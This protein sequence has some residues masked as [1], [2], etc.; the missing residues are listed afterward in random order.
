MKLLQED[1]S[2]TAKEILLVIT[3]QLANNSTPAFQPS[4]FK[5]P[6]WAVRVNYYFFISISCSLITALAAVLALQWLGSYDRALNQSSPEDR[7]LQRQFRNDGVERWKMEQII[8][9]LPAV[10]FFALLIFSIGLAD[11]LWHLHLGVAAIAILC[12]IIGISFFWITTFISIVDVRA[13][14]RTPTSRSLPV[15][16]G[17]LYQ[18]T[19][20]L[21]ALFSWG[22]IF[23]TFR[24]SREKVTKSN[25]ALARWYRKQHCRSKGISFH[26]AVG[27]ITGL[28]TL[29]SRWYRRWSNSGIYQALKYLLQPMVCQ[30]PF[31]A[32]ELVAI[33]SEESIRRI[34]LLWLARSISI[35]PL[36][37][38]SFIILIQSFL[39]LPYFSK[40]SVD[41]YS[42]EELE[43]ISFLLHGLAFIGHEQCDGSEFND[44]YMNFWAYD[45]NLT[46]MYANL[47]WW[48]H[49]KRQDRDIY[50]KETLEYTIKYA[51]QWPLETIITAL[52]CVKADTRRFKLDVE[53]TTLTVSQGLSMDISAL[54][55]A[56]TMPLQA[57]DIILGIVTSTLPRKLSLNLDPVS[58]YLDAVRPHT[59]I[60]VP[61]YFLLIHEAITHQ[62]CAALRQ[63]SG[64]QNVRNAQAHQIL[65][66]LVK[67][68]STPWW[69][70]DKSSSCLHLLLALAYTN[71]DVW[72][73][74]MRDQTTRLLALAMPIQ[75]DNGDAQ[76]EWWINILLGFEAILQEQELDAYFIHVSLLLNLQKAVRYLDLEERNFTADQTARLKDI[77]DPYVRTYGLADP[78]VSRSC[79]INAS[80]GCP[81]KQ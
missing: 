68:F 21:F 27:E 38:N 44:L 40:T 80:T 32:R 55:T 39:D 41:D 56:P 34:G 17:L 59:E 67:L 3:R 70:R 28:N 47:A 71:A 4:T 2:D 42:K 29:P 11:W 49:L 63:L 13:P 30:D 19:S 76:E 10:I 37:R 33:D 15:Y 23:A 65:P 43:E 26:K 64:P 25:A 5:A 62:L 78:T 53:E 1:S 18:R 48:R 8:G 81:P 54:S 45:R 7:A 50:A 52:L 6:D 75:F 35:V 74:D 9:F 24:A 66:R 69:E 51:W 12:I 22:Q 16:L 73:S 77:H 20:A 31:E 79:I 36:Q 14:F 60:V 58:A 57:L 46:R 72:T 61:S